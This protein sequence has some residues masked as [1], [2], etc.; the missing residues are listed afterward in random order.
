MLCNYIH[1]HLRA[2]AVTARTAISEDRAGIIE[3]PASG[4]EHLRSPGTGFFMANIITL[5]RFL[6]LFVLVVIAYQAPPALQLLN[7]PLLGAIFL[8]DAFDGYVARLRNE[9]SQ[10]GAL[11]DI[12]VDRVVENV[13]WVVMADLDLVPVWVTILFITRSFLVDTIRSYGASRGQTPFGMMS[14]GIGRFLVAGRTLRFLY[15][16][17]KALAFGYLLL[18]YP[19]PA[20]APGFYDTWIREIEWVKGLLVYTAVIL[21]VLRALPV[22]VEFLL[23]EDGPFRL[24]MKQGPP[25]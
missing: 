3:R 8:M 24:S 19:L 4:S 1:L 6:L 5:S 2:M 20:I 13:L 15:G 25:R 10:F 14:S 22:L 12:A 7:V 21:C 17:A 18:I 11:F 9:T 23:R 16:A